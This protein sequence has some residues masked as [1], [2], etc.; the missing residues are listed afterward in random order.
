MGIG[1]DR[2]EIVEADHLNV[3]TTRLDDG[4]QDVAANAAKTVDEDLNRHFDALLE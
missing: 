2:T 1:L 3:G 4:A